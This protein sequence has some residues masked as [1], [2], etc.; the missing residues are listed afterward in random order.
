MTISRTSPERIL[1]NLVSGSNSSSGKGGAIETEILY[2]AKVVSIDDPYNSKRIKVRIDGEDNNVVDNDL[3]WCF[4]MM[5]S[6]FHCIPMVGE[7][8]L[9]VLKN[10]WNKKHS[11]FW[12]GP[13]FADDS[14]KTETFEDSMDGL[15]LNVRNVHVDKKIGRS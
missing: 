4:S 7:H 3:P 1:R 14:N 15:S 5:P 12:V 8:V 10:P 11:R 2:H 9:C 13:I 6:F